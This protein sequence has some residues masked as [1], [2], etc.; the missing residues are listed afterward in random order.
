M[1]GW[2]GTPEISFYNEKYQHP[3][4]I[5]RYSPPVLGRFIIHCN[6]QKKMETCVSL[7]WIVEHYRVDIDFT[8]LKEQKGNRCCCG[9]VG[10][11]ESEYRDEQVH[12]VRLLC[13]R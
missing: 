3:G 13:Y 11:S 8:N 1:S 5:E 4:R 6:Y 2:A 12:H 10:V 7:F 9:P